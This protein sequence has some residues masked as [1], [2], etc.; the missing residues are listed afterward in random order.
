MGFLYYVLF[1]L[2]GI[3]VGRT[4]LIP[5]LLAPWLANLLYGIAG[6]VSLWRLRG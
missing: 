5:P 3:R 2:V 1:F 4:G 6:V